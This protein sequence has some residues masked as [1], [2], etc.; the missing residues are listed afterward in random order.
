MSYL[1]DSQK[2]ATTVS[3][4]R[5][6]RQSSKKLA[7]SYH[8]HHHLNPSRLPA[9]TLATPSTQPP[10]RTSARP[11]ISVPSAIRGLSSFSAS[12]QDARGRHDHGI[13]AL[14]VAFS[15]Q[16]EGSILCCRKG[17]VCCA[18]SIPERSCHNHEQ[19]VRQD[20]SGAGSLASSA[21]SSGPPRAAFQSRPCLKPQIAR[22]DSAQLG[23]LSRLRAT[24]S[25]KSLGGRSTPFDNPAWST[26]NPA[27]IRLYEPDRRSIEYSKPQDR[28]HPHIDGAWL[29]LPEQ[30][31]R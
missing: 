3:G 14:S 20:P 2:S 22:L 29:P 21:P 25:L 24:R 1:E 26:F 17:W 8:L 27:S 11:V 12:F 23:L 5:R 18:M 30:T 19:Y 10:R 15:D 28:A 4:V 16:A 7:H 13:R 6:P 9:V 31:F